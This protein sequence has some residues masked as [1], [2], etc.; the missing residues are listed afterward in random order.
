[1]NATGGAEERKFNQQQMQ[2]LFNENQIIYYKNLIL[3]SYTSNRLLMAD[4]LG[5]PIQNLNFM[6]LT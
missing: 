3:S 2:L 5:N 4:K 6:V 1:M